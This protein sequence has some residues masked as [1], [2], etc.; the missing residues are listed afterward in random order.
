MES[1]TPLWFKIIVIVL[2]LPLIGFPTL[3]TG[4]G[5]LDDTVRM[6]LWL[7]PLY[8]LVTGICATM[9]YPSRRELAWIL[10]AVMLLSHAGIYY[11]ALC[12]Y[13]L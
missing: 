6:L 11:L 10:L 2:M 7:Y 8:V 3:L 5:E 9:C 13:P 12:K 1:K 4:M